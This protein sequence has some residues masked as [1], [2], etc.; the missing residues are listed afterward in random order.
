MGVDLGQPSFG[1]YWM[2]GA[3]MH[4]EFNTHNDCR[5]PRIGDFR[6]DQVYVGSATGITVVYWEN[7][8]A[9]GNQM[10]GGRPPS[11]HN[12]I[13]TVATFQ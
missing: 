7:W 8:T 12:M 3:R 5:R 2:T 4:P 9:F 11:D 13:Y 10:V 1:S 6:I